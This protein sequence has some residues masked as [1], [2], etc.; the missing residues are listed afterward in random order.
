[1][2]R[3]IEGPFP[4]ARDRFSTVCCTHVCEC[5]LRPAWSLQVGAGHAPGKSPNFPGAPVS[6]LHIMTSAPTPV[7]YAFG[8][9]FRRFPGAIPMPAV[10]QSP[11]RSPAGQ[12]R[13][14]VPNARKAKG[15]L[16]ARPNNSERR[17]ASGNKSRT[18]SVVTSERRFNPYVAQ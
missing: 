3:R 17:P 5:S 9:F 14:M 2:R 6:E 18:S 4:L 16:D 8:R 12:V 1:M 10:R 11:K 13:R 15:I 7:R